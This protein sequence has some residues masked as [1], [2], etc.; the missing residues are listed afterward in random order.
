MTT[1]LE[2]IANKAK[3]DPKLRFTSLAHHLTPESLFRSLKRL[4]GQTGKGV[5]KETKDEALQ[6]F[7]EW[8]PRLLNAVHQLGHKPPPVR[9]VFIPKPGKKEMRPI[10]V[11]TV[12][13]RALQHSVADILSSIY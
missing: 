5:D 6:S 2:K 11:P 3:L 10:G 1:G 9:R 13:D 4:P 8:S 12:K 7:E